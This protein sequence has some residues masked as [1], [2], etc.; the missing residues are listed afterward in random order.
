M[1]NNHYILDAN[2]FITAHRTVYPLDV[3]PSFWNKIQTLAHQGVISSIDKVKQELTK[4]EDELCTWCENHLPNEFW[5]ASEES[6]EEYLKV[7]Q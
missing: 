2:V 3:V 5:Q 4:Y 7:I 1:G 6:F